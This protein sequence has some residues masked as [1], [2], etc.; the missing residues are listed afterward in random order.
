MTFGEKYGQKE[1][2]KR[3]KYLK[4][5]EVYN[6]WG[7]KDYI[8]DKLFVNDGSYGVYAV[9]GL[10]EHDVYVYLPMHTVPTVNKILKDTDAMN[11][12]KEGRAGIQIY[13]YKAKDYGNKECYGVNFVD[14]LPF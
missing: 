5:S 4:L 6:T 12:I 8:L 7:A 13:K 2:G 11:D 1:E 3:R 14:I 10:A 9:A